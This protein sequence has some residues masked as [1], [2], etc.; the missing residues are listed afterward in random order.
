VSAPGRRVATGRLRVDAGRAVAKLREYQLLERRLWI[1]EA[2][3]GAV[4]AGAE[5]IRVDA[6]ADD[7]WV[8]WEGEPP[9][10]DELGALLDELVSPAVDPKRRWARLLATAVNTALGEGTRF[11]DVWRIDG[12]DSVGFRYAPALLQERDE[13][14]QA[15]RPV[16]HD[17][18][19][20]PVPRMPSRGVVVQARRRFGASVMGRWLTGS[21]PPELQLLREVS[22]QARSRVPLAIGDETTGADA[23]VLVSVP[24]GERARIVLFR[25]GRL[26]PRP[27]LC[28][29]L[30]LGVP[31]SVTAPLESSAP[32]GWVPAGLIYDADR[33]PTNAARSE[34]RL[35][36][37]GLDH[38][39]RQATGKGLGELVT[40]TVEA[41]REAREAGDEARAEAL[42]AAMLAWVGAHCGGADWRNA[43]GAVPSYLQPFRKLELVRNAVGQWKRLGAIE[44]GPVL[45]SEEPEEADLEPW[46]RR[47]L[48]APPG[49]PASFLFAGQTP[50][51][52]RR[53]LRAAGRMLA[54]KRRWM[55]HE[56]R[57]A[58]VPDAPG[59]WL[60]VRFGRNENRGR[61]A[62][63]LRAHDRRQHGEVC[64][65]DPLSVA[66]NQQGIGH[67][68][69]LHQGRPL[70]TARFL[71]AI[72]YQAVVES[73]HLKPTADY[74]DC[75]PN[76]GYEDALV[77]TQHF[78]LRAAE[79]VLGLIE[80]EERA[81]PTSARVREPLDAEGRLRSLRGAVAQ[82]A[83]HLDLNA[84]QVVTQMRG[85]FRDAPVFDLHEDDQ[86]H[87]VSLRE[88]C[89]RFEGEEVMVQAS[90][91][92]Q[93]PA[94]RP[95]VFDVDAAKLLRRRFPRKPLVEYE[96][97]LASKRPRM[98][99][100]AI[101]S[102]IWR[103]DHPMLQ[104]DLGDVR[105]AI[106]W[107]GLSHGSSVLYRMH[108]GV[109]IDQIPF[110]A[111][112]EHCKVAMDDDRLI[113]TTGWD[114]A[115][116]QPDLD[117]QLG[118]FEQ[119]ICRAVVDALA[120]K[121]VG[122]LR[123]RGD[124][125]KLSHVHAAV[126]RAATHPDA[127]DPDRDRL[128]R[129]L[130]L[131]ATVGGEKRTLG[132]LA[133]LDEIRWVQRHESHLAG[134]PGELVVA[135]ARLAE[136]LSELTG[137]PQRHAKRE[138]EEARRNH[139]RATN[140][141]LHRRQA[142]RSVPAPSPL[143]AEVRG[144]HIV[145]GVAELAGSGLSKTNIDVRI[146]GR[147]FTRLQADGP[148]IDAIVEV[149]LDAATGEFDGL[150]DGVAEALHARVCRAMGAMLER[151][152][153]RE[154][155]LLHDHHGWGVLLDEWLEDHFL[156]QS[157]SARRTRQ[158]LTAA[159]AFP[160]TQGG[161]ISIDAASTDKQVRVSEVLGDWLWPEDGGEL[162]YLD[163]PTL[164]VGEP[165][166]DR[167]ERLAL[168]KRLYDTT[169]SMRRLQDSRR[170]EQGL[171][172]RPVLGQIPAER[173]ASLEELGGASRRRWM[174]GEIGLDSLRQASLIV[175]S[176]GHPART[177]PLDM[178]P[179]VQIALEASDLAEADATVTSSLA[180]HL[181][182][183]LRR[184]LVQKILPGLDEL[185]RWVDAAVRRCWLLDEL[186]AD[187]DVASLPLFESTAGTRLSLAGVR[188]Q[189]KR[190]GAVWVTTASSFLH[191]TR[192]PIDPE[193]IALRMSA[194]EMAK[195]AMKVEVID[196]E[197]ELKL[198]E[199]LRR[200]RAR[201]RV[202]SLDLP[203]SVKP[204]LLAS[205]TVKKG[206]L[207]GTIG[208]LHGSA[209]PDLARVHTSRER[210][211]LGAMPAPA[212]WP[213][214][215][216]VDDPR[217]TPDRV[218]GAPEA[219]QGWAHA[220]E[221]LR[222]ERNAMWRELIPDAPEEALASREV[223]SNPSWGSVRGRL[224][225]ANPRHAGRV[226]VAFAHVSQSVTPKHEGMT[227]PLRGSLWVACKEGEKYALTQRVLLES[228]VRL[229]RQVESEATAKNPEAFAVL[230]RAE[231]IDAFE[232]REAVRERALPG[233]GGI[234]IDA[235]LTARMAGLAAV[236]ALLPPDLGDAPRPIRSVLAESFP[237]WVLRGKREAAPVEKPEREKPS[238]ST[239]RRRK[240]RGKKPKRKAQ[241]KAHP[242]DFLAAGLGK[243]LRELG[244][245]AKVLV[246]P[247]RKKR[248]LVFD[249]SHN[250]LV[251]SGAHPQ[252]VA[253]QA[254]RVARGPN[255]DRAMR[256]LVA[257]AVGVLDRALQAV[258]AAS[259]HH[260][261]KTLL[262]QRPR[263]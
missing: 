152:A 153:E 115:A 169:R 260:A 244:M 151:V 100:R 161:L 98:D 122:G 263:S 191:Q 181:E 46:L 129:T 93:L 237:S 114:A 39:V 99:E 121:E 254:E 145:K 159:V 61:S 76:K 29:W 238:S 79:L 103:P 127:L 255:A 41:Y 118:R 48:W 106:A 37:G 30:E 109:R 212:G 189:E 13:D 192:V 195:L 176:G 222:K 1:L 17:D 243:A 82:V 45:R 138:L 21:E 94:G 184:L 96:A 119:A 3:R 228:F 81:L 26:G 190:F 206:A 36:E 251:L 205:R 78:A 233:L 187:D 117:A 87:R 240:D 10:E 131:I 175:Y 86:V 193:R 245:P 8:S 44:N 252:L 130:P 55:E 217:L 24:L 215:A 59:Q 89:E 97:S 257:H 232:C 6:D 160:A 199:D 218:H 158:A 229:C 62:L 177:I 42:R 74:R 239:T 178:E 75:E 120:G 223:K 157:R 162:H 253:L 72:P 40:A 220:T 182:E 7:V 194:H 231:L 35:D 235:L 155:R 28:H 148:P 203:A 43:L 197:E 216:V 200:N 164:A 134:V 34:V 124:I 107:S 104:V 256:L 52:P 83:Q 110:E 4:G 209:R 135:D 174:I 258:T 19:R 51:H 198:D 95:L 144:K 50:P 54:A 236:R 91:P 126:L 105:G 132:E 57:P 64:L 180:A 47:I 32:R 146:E 31:L 172:E 84:K 66:P 224:W 133:E 2:L 80:D 38:V 202:E 90:S 183:L 18:H 250:A 77:A 88:L 73:D 101:R 173:K 11:V 227:L 140:L 242:L 5:S 188:A 196:A 204:M 219:D 33:L 149:E 92:D 211:P 150:R 58:T 185:P 53:Q 247:R 261:T 137:R 9:P 14:D 249:E 179:T 143:G 167:I 12:E 85:P 165:H 128:L 27:F 125:Q 213:L 226:Q 108:R 136:V 201:P 20:P 163:S 23:D 56:P 208:L 246:A 141:T 60:S 123:I 15:L 49:D 69:L 170:I 71:S 241:R 156:K 142:E 166:R 68:T 16:R 225:L 171:V 259:Q 207:E 186:L 139:R 22:A 113:P 248:L 262:G 116:F 154:P 111:A 25:A 112:F 210:V 70:A 102:A 221:V 65:L 234:S 67:V 63:P 230:L 147:A 214:V 168:G